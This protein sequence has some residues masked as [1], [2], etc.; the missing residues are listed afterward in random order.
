MWRVAKN[1]FDFALKLDNEKKKDRLRNEWEGKEL[2]ISG[3]HFTN[4]LWAG[5]FV[6]AAFLNLNYDFLAQDNRGKAAL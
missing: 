1:G 6:R 3:V 4:I 2:N 5:F